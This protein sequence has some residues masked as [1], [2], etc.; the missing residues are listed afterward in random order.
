MKKIHE[1]V[2]ADVAGGFSKF[3]NLFFMKGCIHSLNANNQQYLDLL[4]V[5]KTIENLVETIR[6][7]LDDVEK[8]IAECR[9]KLTEKSAPEMYE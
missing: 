2:I 3:L 4:I 5:F 1:V 9:R 7:C 8:L 6:D